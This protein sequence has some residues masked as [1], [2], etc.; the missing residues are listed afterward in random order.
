MAKI[1]QKFFRTMNGLSWLIEP[2]SR[3]ERG[4]DARRAMRR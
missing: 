3:G 2:V 1:I 4:C